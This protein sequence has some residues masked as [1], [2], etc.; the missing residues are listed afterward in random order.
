MG[1]I[2]IETMGSFPQRKETFSAMDHGH[3]RAVADAIKWLSTVVLPAAIRQ[4]H[5]FHAEG[6]EPEKGFG[7]GSRRPD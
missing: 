3:A 2:K 7:Q 6:A 4:D 1:L 5:T